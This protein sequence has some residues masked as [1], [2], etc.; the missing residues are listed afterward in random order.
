MP[1]YEERLP[2]LKNGL[3]LEA[4][5]SKP[6][7]RDL[8]TTMETFLKT[9]YKT[10]PNELNYAEFPSLTFGDIQSFYENNIKDK[11]AVITIYGDTS[12]FDI[13]QLRQYGKVVE[14]KLDTIRTE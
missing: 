6:N 14:L 10:D 7:F 12:E 5:S 9:G 2:T 4:G 1:K 8:S 11:P 13:D 3:L